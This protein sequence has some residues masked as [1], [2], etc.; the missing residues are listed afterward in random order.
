[1]HQIHVYEVGTGW[2]WELR[3]G[4]RVVLIGWCKTREQAERSARLA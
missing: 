4:E 2:L 3:I 1:M